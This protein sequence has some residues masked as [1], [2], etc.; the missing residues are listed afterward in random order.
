MFRMYSSSH[1]YLYLAARK[2]LTTFA[3]LTIIL[4]L[5]TI[6]NACMCAHNFDKGLKPYVTRRRPVSPDMEKTEYTTE[7]V[8]GSSGKPGIAPPRRVID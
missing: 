1:A 2:E 4:L 3:V 5:M 7:M 6:V 8:P